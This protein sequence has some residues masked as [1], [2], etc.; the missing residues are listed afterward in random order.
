MEKDTN[1][2]FTKFTLVYSF[3]YT[4]QDSIPIQSFPN[5]QP[6]FYD[7]PI[8]ENA[9]PSA[10]VVVSAEHPFPSQPAQRQL[11]I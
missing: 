9:T 6:T 8:S 2:P 3:Q 11:E 10:A 5:F 7:P 1:C 4:V